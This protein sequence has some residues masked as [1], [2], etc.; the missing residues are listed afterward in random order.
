[1]RYMIPPLFSPL[2]AKG[3]RWKMP[4]K[5]VSVRVDVPR[6]STRPRELPSVVEKCQ[7][8]YSISTVDKLDDNLDC[9]RTVSGSHLF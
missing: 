5:L 9:R 4:Q 1:M 7:R 2:H 3:E 6:A 8:M